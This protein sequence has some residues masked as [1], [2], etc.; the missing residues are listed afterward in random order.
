LVR[1]SQ[2]F[3]DLR[4]RGFAVGSHEHGTLVSHELSPPVPAG[5]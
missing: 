1:Y 3:N 5:S 4:D 2:Y